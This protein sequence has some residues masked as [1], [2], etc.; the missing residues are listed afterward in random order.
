MKVSE[1]IERA[2]AICPELAS[3]SRT[4]AWLG[5]IEE[6]ITT[7]LAL[8]GYTKITNSDGE[9]ELKAPEYLA[10]V[11]PL[12]IVMK[13]DLASSDH[14]RYVCHNS[15]FCASYAELANYFMRGRDIGSGNYYKL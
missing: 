5:E 14:S 2:S 12:Y 1:A 10:E 4:H 11:Y 15:A 6:R 7:E 8:E 9:R 13:A 3:D